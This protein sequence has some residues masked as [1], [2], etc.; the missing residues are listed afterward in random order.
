MKTGKKWIFI[1]ILAFC[2]SGCGKENRS[3]I[4]SGNSVNKVLE[5]QSASEKQQN[6]TQ[7]E[8]NQEQEDTNGDTD[9]RED[10]LIVEESNSLDTSVDYDLTAMN[11]DMV[12]ST[13]YQLMMDPERY[14]GKTFK[15]DGVYYSGENEET[16][17]VY[18][19]CVIKDALACCA[20]GLEF[21]KDDGANSDSAE[22]PEEETEIEIKGTFETY[23]EANDDTLYCRIA[24]AQMKIK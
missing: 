4:N 8:K 22:Y 17:T 11:S 20:Q 2:L 18:H 7:D 3:T 5:E 14:V 21:V 12:Y 9:E 10:T 23:K 6:K 1:C 15:L 16:G 13:V 19:Y 24:N